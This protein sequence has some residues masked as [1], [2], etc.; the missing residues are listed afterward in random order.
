MQQGIPVA[1]AD[2]LLTVRYARALV[3]HHDSIT[4]TMRTNVSSNT[5]F[6]IGDSDVKADYERQLHDAQQVARDVLA[7]ALSARVAAPSGVSPTLTVLTPTSTLPLPSGSSMIVVFNALGDTQQQLVQ[8]PLPATATGATVIDV[9]GNSL[10][11][12]VLP[13]WNNDNLLLV[14]IATIGPLGYAVYNVNV[15]DGVTPLDWP[16]YSAPRVDT[17]ISNGALTA[18][19]DGRSGLLSSLQHLDQRPIPVSLNMAHFVN[20]T[21][22]AYVLHENGPAQPLI[23]TPT[24]RL[25]QGPVVEQ[26]CQ[27]YNGV[28]GINAVC[29]SLLHV[30]SGDACDNADVCGNLQVLHLYCLF[31]VFS[32]VSA[33]LDLFSAFLYILFSSQLHFFI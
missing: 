9:Q 7:A 6:F 19:F 27:K 15:R 14:F 10:P 23:N 13:T 2:Q 21:G 30:G 25:I 16:L 31:V 8:V 12:Q 3:Q 17:M 29:Y 33:I 11:C 18:T 4:G 22:G 24:L 32:F 1:G 5:S 26:V 20:A 28:A